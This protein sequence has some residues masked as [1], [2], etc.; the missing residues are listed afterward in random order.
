LKRHASY[1]LLGYAK[2]IRNGIAGFDEHGATATDTTHHTNTMTGCGLGF[3]F[4][5][6]G[7]ETSNHYSRLL[8]FPD[9]QGGGAGAF[10][11]LLGNDFVQC[12]MQGSGLRLHMDQFPGQL[13][14]AHHARALRTTTPM[15]C[16]SRPNISMSM[17]RARL[18]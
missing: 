13:V 17:G 6:Q 2:R 10:T 1:K 14:P 11:D 16:G 9:T 7:L 12:H 18:T 4:I 3:N 15:A 8:P 5:A